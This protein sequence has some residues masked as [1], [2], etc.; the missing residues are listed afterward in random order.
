MP[1][2]MDI[3]AAIVVAI[4]LEAAP[5]L[6]LGALVGAV[7][8]VY[9]GSRALN[10]ITPRNPLAQV[11]LG[12]AG[13]MALPTC[14]CG[15]VPIVR[16]FLARGVPPATALTYMLA[17]PIL[18]PVVLASTWVAFRGDLAVVLL[19]AGLAV[20]VAG[21]LGLLFS[22]VRPDALLRPGLSASL[23]CSCH[24]PECD[25]DHEHGHGHDQVSRPVQVLWHTGREFLGMGVYLVLGAVT[26]AAIKTWVPSEV[27]LALADR[28]LAAVAGMMLLAVLLSVCSEADAFVAASFVTFSLSAKVSFLVIGPMLDL[29]LLGMYA[30]TFRRPV[31]LVLLLVPALLIFGACG[32]LGVLTRGVAW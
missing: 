27:L 6:L 21:F 30:A 2:N 22:R 10:R 16:R 23:S 32:L 9:V 15:V 20:G 28:P 12:L 14:E 25:H 7:F 5:F 19:R 18:N 11:G 13:G 24:G 3:F 17:A 29:K 4:V 26:A 8:E 1:Q 31:V